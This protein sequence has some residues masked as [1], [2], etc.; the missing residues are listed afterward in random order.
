MLLKVAFTLTQLII[1]PEYSQGRFSFLSYQVDT[2]C[3]AWESRA[4]VGVIDPESDLYVI[5]SKVVGLSVSLRCKA[6]ISFR[7]GC[8]SNSVLCPSNAVVKLA[9][10]TSDQAR[11]LPTCVF[12]PDL[13]DPAGLCKP[14]PDPREAA[15]GTQNRRSFRL[16]PRCADFP[17]PLSPPSG[18][19][20]PWP[21]GTADPAAGRH[22]HTDLNTPP[23]CTY[24]HCCTCTQVVVVSGVCADRWQREDLCSVPSSQV[25]WVTH[26]ALLTLAESQNKSQLTLLPLSTDNRKSLL[27]P[28][29]REV[30]HGMSLTK[31]DLSFSVCEWVSVDG[32]WEDIML[33]WWNTKRM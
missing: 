3:R 7:V 21:G 26:T 11:F 23:D 1:S 13:S 15:T 17:T 20:D 19:L 24:A 25:L 29:W 4:D 22:A 10:A 31:C 9:P 14:S 32:E 8:L 30:R 28:E 16:R 2:E 12:P 27:E 5:G 33:P 6:S 18:S